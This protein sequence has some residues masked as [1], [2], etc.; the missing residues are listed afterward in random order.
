MDRFFVDNKV[1]ST[2]TITD[3]DEIKH[4]GK[5][6]RLKEGHKVEIFSKEAKEYIA[7]IAEISK[8]EIRL[9]IL[10]EVDKKRELDC[11]IT[12]YQ[13]I[14]KGQKMELI[15]QKATELGVSTIVPC[16]LRRCVSTI[17]E[18]EDKKIL[19]WQKIAQEA[20]KQSKR[21]IV[22]VIENTM[23]IYDMVEDMKNNQINILFY[24]AEE[25]NSIKQYIRRVQE[26]GLQVKSAG[27]IIGAEGGLEKE[28]CE[29][30]SSAGAEIVTLGD[31]ILRTETAAIYGATIL[32]YE[33]E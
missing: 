14:P 24:E 17:A 7:E 19:R 18:K 15:V 30:L 33:F 21:L 4:I 13:G 28:E 20:S 16:Q 12:I 27:I 25:G 1:G 11:K 6:L 5:V 3:K 26:S 8:D 29:I 23:D 22:P 9:D 32:A 31:R 2:A 10:E